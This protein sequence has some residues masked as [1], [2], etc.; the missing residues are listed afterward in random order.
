[1]TVKLKKNAQFLFNWP[2]FRVAA[3]FQ[4]GYAGKKTL[5]WSMVC[6]MPDAFGEGKMYHKI[7]ECMW[8]AHIS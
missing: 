3:W 8:D 5:G 2:S 4:A 1:L 6:Y 7:E